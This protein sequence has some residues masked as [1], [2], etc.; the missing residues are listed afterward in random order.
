M[1]KRMNPAT[2]QIKLTIGLENSCTKI[3]PAPKA[4]G[5][6]EQYPL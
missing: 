4:D 2:R 6:A 5:I 1:K 3:N